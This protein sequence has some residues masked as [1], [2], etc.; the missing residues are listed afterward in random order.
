MITLSEINE[1]YRNGTPEERDEFIE[2]ILPDFIK[3]PKFQA[4]LNQLIETKIAEHEAKKDPVEELL[5]LL[6]NPRVQT[7]LNNQAAEFLVCSDYQ[8]VTRL[9]NLD[10]INGIYDYILED[11]DRD[12]NIPEKMQA[13]EK[14][15]TKIETNPQSV[16][17]PGVI[18]PETKTEARAV[19]LVEY[20]EK[21]VK[22]RNGQFSL[23]GNEIKDVLTK[24]IPVKDPELAP[25]K[26]QNIRKIKKDV[27][28]KVKSIFGNKIE[29]S[30][31]K[32]GRHETRILL[33]SYPN[34]T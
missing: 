19:F 16:I 22:E 29:I 20:L 3:N 28:A 33:R 34:V 2:L 7:F 6:E 24:V 27:L 12:P 8:I 25:K 30:P 4:Y 26:D 14:R 5:K 15:L 1:A 23:N 32:Y 9:A 31:N 11:E 18:N 10:R 13:I 17:E 21:E